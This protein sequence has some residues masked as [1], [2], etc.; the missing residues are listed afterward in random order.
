MKY[1]EI[2]SQFEYFGKTYQAHWVEDEPLKNFPAGEK[3]DGIHSFCFCGDKMVVVLNKKG[4]WTPPGGY[5]EPEETYEDASIR[6]IKEETNMKV[7][8]QKCLG[9]QDVTGEDTKRVRQV[10]MF[11][12]VEPYGDFISDPD[13]D[14]TEIKLIDPRDYK[15]YFDWS[16]IGDRIMEIALEILKKYHTKN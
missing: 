5:I 10:R 2:N 15:Q 7:L 14:V 13:G 12:I 6:E 11:C 1:M 8:Y 3:L 4:M 9:Y 16:K